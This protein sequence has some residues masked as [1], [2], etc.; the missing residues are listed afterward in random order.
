MLEVLAKNNNLWLKMAFDICKDRDTAKD[1]V[2][3]M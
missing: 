3:D 1:M 2:Q